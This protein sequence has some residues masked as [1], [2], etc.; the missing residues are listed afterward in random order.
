M[1]K[2]ILPFLGTAAALCFGFIGTFA[3]SN[4]QAASAASAKTGTGLAQHVLNAYDEGWQY[5]SGCY[6]QF[7]G[8][9]R[10]SDC[11]G[12]IKS[13]LWWTGSGTDPNPSLSSVAGSS[14]SML[15]AASV[16]GSINLSDSS[17][18][19]RIQGLILYSPGHVGVYVGDNMEVDN[20]CSGENMRKQEVIGGSYHWTKWFKLPQL[21]YP[22]TGFVTLNDSKYYYEDG[23]YVADTTKTIDGTVYTFDASG[24]ASSSS[25]SAGEIAESSDTASYG[26]LKLKSEG[27]EVLN[28]QKKLI[29]DGFMNEAATGY[30]GKV[31]KAAVKA[32]QKSVGLESTGI[33]DEK[34]QEYLFSGKT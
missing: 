1:K 34:T 9:V 20:R 28:L 24:E 4:G 30:Y 14:N 22:T 8:G 10:A 25:E 7:V 5:R 29:A 21:R 3:L 26:T 2:R 31:T 12:L 11:S 23:Q 19:P 33:A 27:E 18:L 32:Y 6:G 17:S 15:S 13:Y 16:K